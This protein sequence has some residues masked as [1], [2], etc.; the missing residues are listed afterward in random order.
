MLDQNWLSTFAGL[1]VVDAVSGSS[2]RWRPVGACVFISHAGFSWVVTAGHVLDQAGASD[3][4]VRISVGNTVQLLGLSDLH[5]HI[6]A[7]WVRDS[8]H[9]VAAGLI[10]TP[11][12]AGFKTIPEKY[13]LGSDED[14]TSMHCY[15]GGCPLG[16]PG[17]DAQRAVPLLLDGIVSGYDSVARRLY[18]STP[19]FPGN[20]GGPILVER[21]LH[22]PGG[23]ITMGRP[24][25][26]LA[27]VVI[28]TA[29]IRGPAD[30]GAAPE[31]VLKLGVGVPI[32]VVTSMLDG[33]EGQQQASIAKSKS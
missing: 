3:L 18:L 23:G 9:D 17:M 29:T 31:L 1:G 25:V 4:A 6:G 14:P 10:A 30:G 7:E 15:T 19:T 24:T 8:H 2:A 5:R 32:D 16:L 20:S 27:G 33:P 26:L 21:P 12:G 22:N 13:L 28:Q 11:K